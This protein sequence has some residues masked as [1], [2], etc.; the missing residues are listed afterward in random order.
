MIQSPVPTLKVCTLN[1][2]SRCMCNHYFSTMIFVVL[3]FNNGFFPFYIEILLSL[4]CIIGIFHAN[5]SFEN[6]YRK[7]IKIHRMLRSLMKSVYFLIFHLLTYSIIIH[8]RCRVLKISEYFKKFSE[9]SLNL[10]L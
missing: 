10:L 6:N 9:Y 2:A 7:Y 5:Y 4:V 1:L 3:F 8:N